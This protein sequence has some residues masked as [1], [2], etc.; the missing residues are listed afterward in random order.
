M[1][2][3]IKISIII[4][5]FNAESTIGNLLNSILEETNVSFEVI[6]VND[7]STDNT[8]NIILSFCDERIK[9]YE[10]SNKGVYFARNLALQ[11]HEGE[12][13]MFLDADDSI[14]YNFLT[15]RLA[16]VTNLNVDVAIFNAYRNNTKNDIKKSIHSNQSY[17]KKITGHQWINDC[18]K[19]REWP[20]YLWLQVVRSDYIKE[21]E[22]KFHA[23]R[24]HKDILWTVD[25]AEANG[26]FIIS[27]RRDYIYHYSPTSITNRS[28]YYD[29]RALDY[30]DI[31][32]TLIKKSYMPENID[33]RKSLI[34][35]ALYECRHYLGLYRKKVKNT[36]KVK[37]A[38]NEH[39][40]LTILLKGI[41][42]ASDLVL[43]VRLAFKM[44]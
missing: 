16:F 31:I 17:N 15:N 5:V 8:K 20:H 11:N 13:V 6:V 32:S 35:H 3:K 26:S 18:V 14:K 41:R 34:Q 37:L 44:A 7:G 22:I 29:F 33:I 23:G 19:K 42:S 27:N 36:K 40:S 24:S 10:Q 25:L 30:I 28:D 21:N 39:V 4:A 43:F 1:R 12:W 2:K 38:F 9:Y